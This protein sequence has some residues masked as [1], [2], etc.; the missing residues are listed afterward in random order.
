MEV[1]ASD[2]AIPWWAL[3][4]ALLVVGFIGVMIGAHQS[5]WDVLGH[6]AAEMLRST[7]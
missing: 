6:R 4:L 2:V 5:T 1:R 3:F 7:P